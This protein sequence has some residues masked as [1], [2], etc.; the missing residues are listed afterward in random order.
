MKFKDVAFPIVCNFS[1]TICIVFSG[2]WA[3]SSLSLSPVVACPN[4]CPPYGVYLKPGP[5]WQMLCILQPNVVKLYG[6]CA[7]EVEQQTHPR[8][9]HLPLLIVLGDSD[10]LSFF[11]NIY[12]HLS[13]CWIKLLM[14]LCIWWFILFFKWMCVKDL[15]R[16]I[17]VSQDREEKNRIET[18]RKEAKQRFPWKKLAYASTGIRVNWTSIQNVTLHKKGKTE[19]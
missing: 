10:A 19:H 11:V 13:M 9:R 16:F 6:H 4:K 8:T 3:I 14:W 5:C 7:A 2:I 12:H 1:I 18:K 15:W 17:I